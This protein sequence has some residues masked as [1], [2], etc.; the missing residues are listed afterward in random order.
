MDIRQFFADPTPTPPL[1]PTKIFSV[2][3]VS[4]GRVV[5]GSYKDRKVPAH[6]R[7]IPML[8][9]TLQQ[10]PLS[11]D[12]KTLSVGRLDITY[13]ELAPQ[14]AVSGVVTLSDGVV[15]IANL[16]N[17]AAG[18]DRFTTID[19][20]ATLMN[21]GRIMARLRLP[22]DRTDDHWELA[23]NCGPIPAGAFNSAL[24]PLMNMQISGDIHRLDFRVAGT[25]VSAHSSVTLRYNNLAV[26]F[27]DPRDHSRRRELL[28]FLAYDFIIR[29]DN[30]GPDQ[31]LREGVGEHKRNTERST[32]NY[33][34]RSVLAGI[35]DVVT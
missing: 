5:V 32:W 16:T 21:G 7:T 14:A 11:F 2:D 34:W 10:L 3:S 1:S 9:Q 23:G 22:V 29:P 17:I 33:I 18:H 27:L 35:L 30:P 19:C 4:I 12:I 6:P 13:E 25:L 24:E 26:E 8:H 31:I 15:R 20:T 28:T